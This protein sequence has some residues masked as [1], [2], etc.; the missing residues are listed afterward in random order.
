[1]PYHLSGNVILT[2]DH[3]FLLDRHDWTSELAEH[4]ANE[5]DIVLT[6]AHWQVIHTLQSYYNTYQ[7]MPALRILIK[8]LNRHHPSGQWSSSSL[9]Q[10]FPNTVL[11]TAAQ[12]AGLPKPQKCL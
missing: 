10:L 6:P 7:A 1:M 9:H 8:L 11:R 12:I 4:I 5:L 2:C 3:G